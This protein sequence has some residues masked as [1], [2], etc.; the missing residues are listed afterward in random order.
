MN[1]LVKGSTVAMAVF[2]IPVSASAQGYD[3]PDGPSWHRNSERRHESPQSFA[4]EVR[5]G[6]YKPLIDDEFGGTGPYESV[7]GS[8][9]R[10]FV[11]V[12]LDY[13]VFRIPYVGTV[14]PGFGWGYTKMSAKAKLTGDGG[15]SAETTGLWIMPMYGVAV[16][17]IDVLANEV[18]IPL[19]PY[20]KGGVGYALWKTSDGAGL[21]TYRQGDETI[22]GKGR[23]YGW[24]FAPGIM[25]Q[26]DPFDRHAAQQLD[27]SVGVNHSYFFLE[28]MRSQL[29]GFGKND[30]MRVGTSTWA[31][32][33]AFEF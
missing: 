21:S 13:Q 17:R 23:S 16:L 29:D 27:N 12:E 26:L 19:V 1:R 8:D 14:G 15:D 10:W 31:A 20:L 5:F 28:W 3:T 30:Q 11:G 9:R 4:L 24:H 25:L 6:H 7:F 22:E 33:L 18:G 2:F 32:G